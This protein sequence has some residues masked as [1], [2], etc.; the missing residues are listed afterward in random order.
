MANPKKTFVVSGPFRIISYGL[1]TRPIFIGHSLYKKMLSDAGGRLPLAG[2]PTD[3]DMSFQLDF[4]SIPVWKHAEVERVQD[5]LNIKITSLAPGVVVVREAIAP[6]LFYGNAWFHL[7]RMQVKQNTL[8]PNNTAEDE[9][10]NFMT[11]INNMEIKAG[12]KR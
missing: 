1:E 7:L 8:R 3:M 2:N 9:Q 12:I 10:T 4:Q 6:F 5:L 11:Q